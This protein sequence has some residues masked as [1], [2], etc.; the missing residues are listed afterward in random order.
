MHGHDLCRRVAFQSIEYHLLRGFIVAQELQFFRAT[1][2]EHLQ[3]GRHL[4][5]AACLA[6]ADFD[7]ASD[8]FVASVHFA[9]FGEDDFPS[10]AWRIDGQGFEEALF[11][12][13]TPDAFGFV[14]D[15]VESAGRR[16]G[17]RGER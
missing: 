7:V 12:V 11:D 1:L 2:G 13:G 17:R 14:A 6:R 16:R 5:A 15:A 9:L 4:L 10:S 8:E 3:M